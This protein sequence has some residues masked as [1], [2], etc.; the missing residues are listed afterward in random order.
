MRARAAH[1]MVENIFH[2]L[3]RPIS[4]L[5]YQVDRGVDLPPAASLLDLSI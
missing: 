2:A 5:E 1:K 3:N 4:D